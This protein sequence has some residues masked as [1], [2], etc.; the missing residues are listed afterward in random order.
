M[1]EHR[2]RLRAAWERLDP[3]NS[4]S[5]R[6]DLPIAW[7]ADDLR[8]SFTLRRGF[9]TPRI[10]PDRESV[11]LE[12][13]NAPGLVAL[14]INGRPVPLPYAQPIRVAI[15]PEL[16]HRNTIEVDAERI[17]DHEWDDATRRWGEVALI[18]VAD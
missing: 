13:S 12:V 10:D 11:N 3:G 8:A 2:I 16:G 1:P 15:G 6:V 17:G 9:G 18:I 7:S 5:R 14:R 4:T